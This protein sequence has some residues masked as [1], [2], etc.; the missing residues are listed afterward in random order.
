MNLSDRNKLPLASIRS[1]L[2]L[3]KPLREADLADE[4][5]FLFAVENVPLSLDSED[6]QLHLSHVLGFEVK[7]YRAFQKEMCFL[8]SIMPENDQKLAQKVNQ[9]INLRPDQELVEAKCKLVHYDAH[10][11]GKKEAIRARLGLSGLGQQI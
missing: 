5:P 7:V 1:S 6:L 3:E 9:L 11:H 2:D 8:T 4:K 10:I